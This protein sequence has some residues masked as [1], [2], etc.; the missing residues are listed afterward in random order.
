MKYSKPRGTNDFIGK[1]AA[2]FSKLEN[3]C[4][5]VGKLYGFNE[6]KTPI[7]EETDLFIRSMGETSDVVKKEMYDFKDKGGRDICLRPE[8]TAPIIR[9]VVE[10]KLLANTN[11]SLRLV[12]CGPV[13]RYDRPQSGRY[14]QFDQLSFE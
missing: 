13:F 8:I 9:A 7:I 1:K 4:L 10:N 2:D 14:R 6:I 3:I 5:E 12:G 11:S